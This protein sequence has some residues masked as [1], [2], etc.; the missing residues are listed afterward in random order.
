MTAPRS[1]AL[2]IHGK[3][4]A[5]QRPRFVRAT[6]RTYTPP[7]TVKFED[8]IRQQA[9]VACGEPLRGPVRLEVRAVFEP[10]PSWSRKKRAAALNGWHTQKPDLDNLVKAIQDGLNRVAFADDS[11]VAEK[12]C[13]KVWG[14]TAV[15]QVTV[16][17]LAPADF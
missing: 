14:E 11:Q 4:F 2:V 7:E 9:A 3:P 6:G 10:P 12:V 8:V 17:E 5:K 13:V 1:F 16:T 15:T